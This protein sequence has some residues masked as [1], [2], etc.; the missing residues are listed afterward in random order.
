M[1]ERALNALTPDDYQ[2]KATDCP[3]KHGRLARSMLGCESLPLEHDQDKINIGKQIPEW[4][5]SV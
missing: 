2:R 4:V 3:Y 5:G 1:E